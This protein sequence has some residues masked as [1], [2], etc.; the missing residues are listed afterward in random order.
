M[1]W[2]EGAALATARYF[3]SCAV[4]DNKLWV[5]G[6]KE[7]PK[8][9]GKGGRGK[10]AQPSTKRKLDLVEVYDQTTGEWSE[11]AHPSLEGSSSG[12]L[13]LERVE[14]PSQWWLDQQV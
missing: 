11:G 12:V 8:P 14:E 6:G 9:K 5:V 1:E 4:L 13:K 10:G 2:S 3:H 7:K